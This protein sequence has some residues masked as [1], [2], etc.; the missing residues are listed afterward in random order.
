MSFF[1]MLFSYASFFGVILNIDLRLDN[2][3]LIVL[4]F[5]YSSSV[6]LVPKLIKAG[7]SRHSGW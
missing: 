4:L 5:R 6:I 3:I 7:I 2:F 1:G